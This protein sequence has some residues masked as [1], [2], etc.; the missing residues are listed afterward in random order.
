MN[1]FCEKI[2]LLLKKTLS[3]TCLTD[4]RNENSKLASKYEKFE[5]KE[6]L[7]MNKDFGRYLTNYL[8]LRNHSNL[9]LKENTI[10]G[11]KSDG[12]SYE[13][14]FVYDFS[15]KDSE[16]IKLKI[17]DKGLKTG[18]SLIESKYL[19]IVSVNKRQFYLLNC[20]KLKENI[21][22]NIKNFNLLTE[23]NELFKSQFVEFDLKQLN[24]KIL[25]FNLK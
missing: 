23:D 11:L 21:K 4:I 12:L 7:E 20:E 6:I 15:D 16:L 3:G 8:L 2:D 1:T 18:I 14:S 10:T 22:K 25:T 5:E 9:I 17:L 13:Y 19:F 24:E